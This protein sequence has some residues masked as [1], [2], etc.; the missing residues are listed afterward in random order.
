M[1]KPLLFSA[2]ALF[3]GAC[4]PVAETPSLDLIPHP[5]SWNPGQ[6]T[7]AI[8]GAWELKVPAEWQ[9]ERGFWLDWL[10]ADSD[11][12]E[13]EAV[14]VIAEQV[15][16][17]EPEAYALAIRPDGITIKAG[18]THGVFH[19]LTTLR[20]LALTSDGALPCGDLADAPRFAHRG[21]LLDC[22]RHF[23]EPEFVKRTID[24]L[25]LHKMSVLHWHLTE[26]QGWRVEIDAYPELTQKGA[27]RTEA[28][29]SQHGGF[30]TK[31]QIRDIVAY[32]AQRHIEVIPEIELPGHSRA[33]LAAYPW[34]GCTGEAMEVPH[35]WGVFK[36]IYCAGQDTTLAFLKTVLDEVMEL[37]PSE[38]IHIGGDEA[39]KVRWEQCPKCQKRIADEGLHDAHELQSWF[40]GEIGRYLEAHGRKMIGWDEILEGGLPDGATVQSW[41]GMDGGRDAVAM[42]HDAIMSPTSHCYFDYPVESTDLEEVYGF[43]PEPE[44]LEGNG[45]ILGGECN[46]WSERAPQHLVES[47]VY[48]RLVAMAEV[49][50]SPPSTRNWPDFQTRMESHYTR[51]DAWAVAYGWETVPMA[52]QWEQGT[53]PNGLRVQ[54]V[55][56]MSGVG[57]TGE[58]VA[59][60]G[61]TTARAMGLEAT[62]EIQGEGELRVALSRKGVSMGD[63]LA[64]PLAGHVGAFRPV[65][66]AHEINA[67]YPGRGEQ[68]LADGRLGSADFRDGS[69][70]ATQ[71]EH[72]GV[73]VQL[74][75]LI[76][77]DSLSMQ[78]YR[79]QDAWIFL[80]DSVRFQWSADGENWN[81]GWWTQPF[82]TSTFDPNDAQDVQRLAFPVGEAA[83]WVRF[84]AR[85][86]GPCPEWHD[87]ASSATWVFLDELVVHS[88]P[89]L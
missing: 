37:F 15:P 62:H 77:I 78:V 50:W 55:P 42:G 1:E 84:E 82:G 35:D 59:F 32:A 44:G 74:D 73:T 2:F 51:L 72:M 23:M 76:E 36:D 20:S 75:A 79:Y 25:A 8:S 16:G 58:F 49:L 70:Q 89:N 68:G 71:G 18:S 30:Y 6:N 53:A 57:G 65:E 40:I 19:G 52:L 13:A 64:F 21:L 17:M 60:G 7:C 81:G 86:P 4:A 31:E 48:P 33:A 28:D 38:Y 29:G 88:Q 41:R 56:A 63:P 10:T 46:M 80:P 39:P 54:L 14:P 87:A 45:R 11:G 3:L 27:W 24:L 43:E 34:L 5:T 26:D 61:E 83:R 85:N 12:Q 22:C 67:Y 69:W 9:Q 66:L 47:K